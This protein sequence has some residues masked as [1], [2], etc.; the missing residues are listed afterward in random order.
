MLVTFDSCLNF[1][2]PWYIVDSRATQHMTPQGKFYTH[3]KTMP[4]PQI[5][6]VVDDG[7]QQ[8]LEIGSIFIHLIMGKTILVDDVSISPI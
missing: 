1:Y 8:A 2:D 7:Q 6:F 5:I 4:Q 3:Y